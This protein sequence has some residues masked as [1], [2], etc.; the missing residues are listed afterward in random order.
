MKHR[1]DNSEY[2]RN[3]DYIPTRLAS[4]VETV[5]MIAQAKCD[6]NPENTVAVVSTAG[7]PNVVLTLTSDVA[8]VYSNVDRIP[9]TGT[10]DLLTSFHVAMVCFKEKKTHPPVPEFCLLTFCCSLCLFH[11]QLVLNHRQNHI[12]HPRIVACVGSPVL[13]AG[14]SREEYMEKIKAVAKK[15]RTA[16]VALDVIS[17]GEVSENQEFLNALYQDVCEGDTS[18]GTMIVVEPGTQLVVDR[19]M[20]SPIVLGEAG[21]TTAAGG[22]PM[23]TSGGLYDLDPELAM[24]LEESIRDEERRKA[25]VA[26]AASKEGAPA[27]AAAAAAAP[28]AG[29]DEMDDD[30]EA[31]LQKAL[32]MSMMPETGAAPQT[33]AAKATPTAPPAAPVKPSQKP[34]RDVDS[35]SSQATDAAG[36][37]DDGDDVDMNDPLIRA[38]L[39]ESLEE[40]KKTSTGASAQPA[41]TQ[42]SSSPLDDP[43]LVKELLSSVGV[44]PTDPMF[45]Q[46]MGQQQSQQ[47]QEQPKKGQ[48]KPEDKDHDKMTDE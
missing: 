31:E 3:G 47:Q 7:R 27:A 4:L 36:T 42:Q 11:Q 48:S 28:A 46:F 29:N 14:M 39:R 25:A 8:K 16:K 22:V 23:S 2:M 15:L 35:S 30:E 32:Q 12:H 17:F 34:K 10:V 6:A 44:D 18:Q 37:F 13:P 45:A 43:Q 19:V 33:P 24:A 20:C 9:I 38:A 21:V 26:A 40:S 1:F 41:A 5:G